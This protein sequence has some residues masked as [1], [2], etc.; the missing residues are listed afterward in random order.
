MSG[1]VLLIEDDDALRASLAQTLE[2]EGINVVSTDH[3]AQA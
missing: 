2:L 3:Y 1:Q